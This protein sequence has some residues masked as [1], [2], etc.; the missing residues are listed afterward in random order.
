[1]QMYKKIISSFIWKT[2]DIFTD[3]YSTYTQGRNYNNVLLQNKISKKC[4]KSIETFESL[5]TIRTSS[6]GNDAK[7]KYI[8]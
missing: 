1:M 6:I 8:A 3:I 2:L 5:Y 4:I 7:M